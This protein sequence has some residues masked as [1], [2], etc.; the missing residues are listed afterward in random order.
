MA[1][2]WLSDDGF[3]LNACLCIR[4]KTTVPSLLPSVLPRRSGPWLCHSVDYFM[5]FVS[6]RMWGTF[7]YSL[8]VQCMLTSWAKVYCFCCH[9]KDSLEFSLEISVCTESLICAQLASSRPRE[10]MLVL[11]EIVFQ[12]FYGHEK[13]Y[14]SNVLA[15]LTKNYY[16][17]HNV[18]RASL[19]VPW[20]AK[21]YCDQR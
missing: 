16:C 3:C 6:L 9:I 12:F 4:V 17:N 7:H 2:V 1:V 13:F 19:H 14:C 8:L 5:F 11:S 10:C 20:F 18:C 15:I 21:R